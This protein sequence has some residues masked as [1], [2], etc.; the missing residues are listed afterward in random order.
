[1]LV[2][3][4][5]RYRL[6][7]V[8]SLDSTDS[9]V[10]TM[11]KLLDNFLPCSWRQIDSVPPPMLNTFLKLA[12]E[13]LISCNFNLTVMGILVFGLFAFVDQVHLD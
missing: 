8:Q 7:S 11:G 2:F 4:D 5:G 12:E 13:H 1:M 3:V 9:H 10:G 6:K